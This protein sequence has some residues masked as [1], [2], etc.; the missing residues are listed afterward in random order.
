MH[1]KTFTT[2]QLQKWYQ[3]KKNILKTYC[4]DL[5]KK[6]SVRSLNQMK[7]P[8]KSKSFISCLQ[9]LM[10]MKETKET[11]ATFYVEW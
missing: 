2:D 5:Q 7:T 11:T 9:F 1:N 4:H 10:Q 3:S 6:V 8:K